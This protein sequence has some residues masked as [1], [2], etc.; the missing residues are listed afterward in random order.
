MALAKISGYRTA[1]HSCGSIKPIIP[2]MI[3][4]GLDILNP[5][6]PDVYDMDPVELKKKFGNRLCF[7]GSISIQHTLPFGT[8]KD[9]REEVRNR[10]EAL[11]PGGGFIFCT[12][13]NIQVDTPLENVEALFEA[14]QRYGQYPGQH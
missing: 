9:V 14:Y 6:Q 4:D 5:I 8:V 10:F 11:G 1:H 12:A 2:D 13:H 7:H 3:E